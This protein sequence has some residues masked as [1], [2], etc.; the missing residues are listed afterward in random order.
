MNKRQRKKKWKKDVPE[1]FQYCQECGKKLNFDN[2]YHMRWG[3]C[4]QF[5]YMYLVGLS[6]RDFY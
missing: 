1:E 4:D 5:C 6:V 3:T 2:Q